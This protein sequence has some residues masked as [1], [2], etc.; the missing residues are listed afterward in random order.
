MNTQRRSLRRIVIAVSTQ[1]VS[2]QSLNTGW[3]FNAQD[4]Y[5]KKI[6]RFTHTLF[7]AIW[8]VDRNYVTRCALIWT[9]D[10]GADLSMKALRII[11]GLR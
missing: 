3:R 1:N 7:P 8:L 5:F 11:V 2:A 9:V 6:A 4:G 10:A